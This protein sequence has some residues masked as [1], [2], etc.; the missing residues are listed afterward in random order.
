VDGAARL[1]QHPRPL[2][3]EQSDRVDLERVEVVIRGQS[4]RGVDKRMGRAATWPGL[5][6]HPLAFVANPQL[7][8]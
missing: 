6:A 7:V 3:A 5:E 2:A 8:H 4:E 1:G